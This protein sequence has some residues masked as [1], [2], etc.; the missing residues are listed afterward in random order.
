MSA[1]PPRYRGR[2][3]LLDVCLRPIAL[4]RRVKASRSSLTRTIPRLLGTCCTPD[5][6]RPSEC[7]NDKRASPA[8][9]PIWS[10]CVIGS[11]FA[12]TPSRGFKHRFTFVSH[13]SDWLALRHLGTG[14]FGTLPRMLWHPC[15]L[16]TGPRGCHAPLGWAA[17]CVREFMSKLCSV[18][19][20]SRGE[21]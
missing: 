3:L 8:P 7:T 15:L 14:G 6:I 4:P 9:L 10:G 2:L 11:H 16:D 18:A 5:A 21:T 20:S 12:A 1:Y 19:L 17:R 13:E